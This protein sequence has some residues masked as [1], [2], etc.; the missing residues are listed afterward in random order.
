MSQL[1]NTKHVPR[2]MP[3]TSSEMRNVMPQNA[4]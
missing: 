1:T 4:S 3:T 2:I